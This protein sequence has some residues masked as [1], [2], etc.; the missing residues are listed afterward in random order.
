MFFYRRTPAIV[1]TVAIRVDLIDPQGPVV[2]HEDS[3]AICQGTFV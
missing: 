2:A 1:A 3:Q